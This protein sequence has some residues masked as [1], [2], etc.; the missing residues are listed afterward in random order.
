MGKDAIKN[1]IEI[2]L[3]NLD[4]LVREMEAL[5]GRFTNEPD[6]IQTRA[7]GS[8]LHDFYCGV[9][10]LFERIAV[11]IDS[12]LPKGEDWHMELLLQMARSLE[13]IRE[14]VIDQN[15]LVKLKE[16]LR[17][18]HLFRNIYGFE[19]KWN[20]FEKLSLS[21]SG[22]LSGLKDNFNALKEAL[23]KRA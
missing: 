14:A 8:I 1:E 2:E 17:F 18:R 19:L 10:K 22:I 23:D 11:N 7:A 20:R 15:L 16:Y 9:E 21:L 6:F 13:G 12:E 5:R 4:R 3:K